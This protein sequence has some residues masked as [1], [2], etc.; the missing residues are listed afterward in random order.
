MANVAGRVAFVAKGTYDE[1]ATYNV[2]EYVIYRGNAYAA[3]RTAVGIPPTD[4]DYWQPLT[5]V[6][7]M[8]GA[9]QTADGEP[10]KVPQPLAGDQGKALFGD[11]TWKAVA[12][13]SAGGVHYGTSTTDGATAAK[14]VTTVGGDFILTA[15]AD[16]VV[17]F[18][19]ADSAG[20]VMLDVDGTGAKPVFSGG[21]AVRAGLLEDTVYEF[22]Y[23]GTEY[24][25]VSGAAGAGGAYY[26]TSPTAGDVAA[27]TVATANGDFELK[28]GA[29]IIAVFSNAD[30]TGDI[31]L[32]IDNTGAKPVRLGGAAVGKNTIVAGIPYEAVFDGT[33]YNMLPAGGHA[34]MDGGDILY[35]RRARMR[36]VNATVTDDEENGETV[37]TVEGGGV[38]GGSTIT[39][40]TNEPTLYGKSV[41]IS[42]GTDSKTA[43]FS[44][45][46]VA[47]FSSVMMTGTLT[48]TATDGTD[49]ATRSLAVPYYGNYAYSLAFWAAN[50][51]INTS[52]A[53]FNGK[54]VTVKKDG[55][56]VG[57]TAFS[58]GSASYV[59][60]EA[61][62]Y[63]FECTLGWKTFT[64]A[65]VSVT[66]E[67]SYN[68]TLNGF[69]APIAISTASE[70]FHGAA[71]N[72]SSSGSAPAAAVAFDSSGNA[73][74][75]AYEP[76]TYTFTVAY[77]GDD[78]SGTVTVSEETAYSVSV[79]YWTAT[80]SVTTPTAQMR[81]QAV[82]VKD[83]EG[84][85]IGT[86]A[87][88]G[89]GYATFA[90]HAADTYTLECALGWRTFSAEAEVSEETTYSVTIEGFV[91]TVSLSTTSEELADSTVS[92]SADGVPSSQVAFQNGA[93]T[94][95]AY[96]AGAYTFSVVYGGET[97]SETVEVAAEGS[98][99]AELN[100]VTVYG[101]HVDGSESSPSAMITYLEDA[102]G[103]TPAHMDY[104]KGAFDY[105]D[106][107]GAFFMPRPCMLKSD[108]TVD[109]YLDPDDY[110][111]KEDGTASDVAN[112]SYNGNAMMKWGRDGKRIWMKIVPDSGDPYS[113]SVYIADRQADDGYHDYPFHDQNGKSAEHFYTPIYNGSLISNKFRSMSGQAVSSKLTAE[114]EQTYAKANGTLW[115]I[116]QKADI[117]LINALL[118]LMAKTTDTKTAYGQGLHTDGSETVN[119]GFRTGV[120]N[121]KGLFYGTNS[122]A[123]ATY[124]NA[125]KVF[126]MENW[127]G[128][129]WRR[130]VGHIMVNGTQKAKLTYGKEDGSTVT[131]FNLTGDGYKA[132]GA[133]PSGTSG[134]YIS[135][136][137]FSENGMFPQVASGTETTYYTNGLWF[138][139]AI[140]AVPFRGGDSNGAARVGAL[141][142][143]L[144]AAA[145]YAS[146][147]I[148]AAPSC[149]PLA[150][151]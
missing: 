113:G 121:T 103:K 130:Y 67:A 96:M 142:L 3:K 75:T 83:G 9:T 48:V 148:G 13:G 146:W 17:K 27:K 91:A 7:D 86:T 149:K 25:L 30:A 12:Q 38:A 94:Y 51:T 137:L 4:T 139:N 150:E 110:T 76:G 125:V 47:A 5:D 87:F 63:T 6:P 117:D 131:G 136:L 55:T 10:G 72:V 11:G 97:Y 109:Y 133:T 15:G 62:N 105:G 126:G 31:S 20:A 101:F 49:T 46:G 140:T 82:T 21:T 68:A 100:L 98:Y 8:A 127:W 66:E 71:V 93:A 143:N 42:D 104:S 84:S 37:V 29:D 70:E 2:L 108:G 99:S 81:G 128:F 22:I 147:T 33:N 124:A 23:N 35:P 138:N 26:G 74:Y 90:V 14:T 18:A 64:S 78:Y 60:S 120:H 36:F 58:D 57:T 151:G 106:W 116:E 43:T 114:Q 19:N 89:N 134:G 123:A 79:N 34:V 115:D 122:G 69:V 141:C 144:G 54:V 73:S 111:K 85:A 132:V 39:V 50:I 92:V 59:A 56:A 129:Q 119:N 28:A 45:G 135:K 40:T 112:T 77:G 145:S 65:A 88:D 52:T 53:Q 16:V 80:L 102:A 95:T 24:D 41:T 1:T 44:S 61:G 118:L 32:N 107:E